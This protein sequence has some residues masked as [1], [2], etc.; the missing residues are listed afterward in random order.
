[1]SFWRGELL[2]VIAQLKELQPISA[3][4]TALSLIG[5]AASGNLIYGSGA[6]T[7]ARL[8]AGT[9][10]Q[11]LRMNAASTAPEWAT[12]REVLTAARTYYVRTDGSD[13]NTGLANTAGGAFLTI[14]KAINTVAALDISIY[15]VTIQVGNGTYTGAASFSAPWVGAG[16]VSLTGDTATPSNV[17]IS[18]TSAN[19]IFVF[20]NAAVSI[21][22]FKLQTTT[23]GCGMYITSG[24]SVTISGKMEY[25][26]C[27]QPHVQLQG[28]RFVSNAKNYTISGGATSH[29][30]MD[31][32][33][34]AQV[35]SSTI[36]TSGT[37][38]FTTGFINCSNSFIQC[39]AN[40]FSGTGA[41]GSRYS[42]TA[43]GIIQTFGSGATYL[44]GNAGGTTASQGQYL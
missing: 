35:V 28:G 25:G 26:A 7:W 19:A 9:S 10:L 39:N 31:G 30:L 42:A 3:V 37:P 21:G 8:A 15:A 2:K 16:S 32:F 40:T 34:Y 27:A 33:S 43:N 44:P 41:T 1:M 5:T 38:A 24:A 11:S 13:G 22:G 36:T 23:S 6:G 29:I 17:V 18:T 12:A 4:L 14:Q 20:N